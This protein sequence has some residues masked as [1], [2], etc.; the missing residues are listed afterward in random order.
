VYKTHNYERPQLNKN[1]FGKKLSLLAPSQYQSIEIL[2]L[3]L[4][5]SKL[6]KFP[7]HHVY[8]SEDTN[9]SVQNLFY[10]Q[11]KQQINFFKKI[12]TRVFDRTLYFYV[13]GVQK[14]FFS[15]PVVTFQIDAPRLSNSVAN[16]TNMLK[17]ENIWQHLR[18]RIFYDN[19]FVLSQGKRKIF[20]A[21]W[22]VHIDE[23]HW[24]KSAICLK[25]SSNDQINQKIW[26]KLENSPCFSIRQ[27]GAI[28]PLNFTS[29]PPP[30]APGA[31][32]C[33]HI[34]RT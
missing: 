20:P 6:K 7:W 25:C 10:S 29:R 18:F 31:C 5:D 33:A 19:I 16:I 17:P 22:R 30:S 34:P 4:S 32:F 14:S 11:S 15:F 13:L 26:K 28:A 12:D 23:W 1:G 27:F 24:T 2:T 9:S 21:A 3:F 8:V